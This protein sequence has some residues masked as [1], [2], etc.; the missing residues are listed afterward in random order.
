MGDILRQ[1]RPGDPLVIPAAAYNTFV[2][3]DHDYLARQQDQAQAA[4]PDGAG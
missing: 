3:A 1:V 2:D 4:R